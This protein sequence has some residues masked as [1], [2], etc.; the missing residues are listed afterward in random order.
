MIIL[1]SGGNIALGVGIYLKL[2]CEELHNMTNICTWA[3]SFETNKKKADHIK[4]S[5]VR[6]NEPITI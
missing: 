2:T 1:R 5:L 3:C 6:I 4:T